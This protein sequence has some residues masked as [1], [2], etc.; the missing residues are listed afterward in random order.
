MPDGSKYILKIY[1][2][3]KRA[4]K[5]YIR[6]GEKIIT[7]QRFGCIHYQLNGVS[8]RR[9]MIDLWYLDFCFCSKCGK[10]RVCEEAVCEP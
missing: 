6:P 7:A 4:D 1:D 10:I 8:R 2:S 5:Q 9:L 3:M